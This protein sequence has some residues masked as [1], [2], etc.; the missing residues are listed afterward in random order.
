MAAFFSI[1][2]F[3]LT[4]VA[5]N[6]SLK[7]VRRV[8]GS[9]LE[10]QQVYTNDRQIHHPG[11][12]NAGTK[13]NNNGHLVAYLETLKSTVVAE[14]ANACVHVACSDGSSTQP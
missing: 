11:W 14:V 5:A 10:C 12:C 6:Q 13:T 7:Q 1:K 4:I 8:G 2:R 3:F 9:E